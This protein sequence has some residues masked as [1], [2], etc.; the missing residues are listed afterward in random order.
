MLYFS[1]VEMP[2]GPRVVALFALPTAL[3]FIVTILWLKNKKKGPAK[4]RAENGEGSVSKL[5]AEEADRDDKTESDA[6]GVATKP[7]RLE[8]EG[9]ERNISRGDESVGA[10]TEETEAESKE[11]EEMEAELNRAD[12]PGKDSGVDI[13]TSSSLER[14]DSSV[15][16]ETT[17]EGSVDSSTLLAFTE[18]RSN[19]GTPPLNGN[20]KTRGTRNTEKDV[21]EIEF[22]Q[23]LCG[24]LIGRKGKN[25]RVISES[26]GAKIR[27]IPQSPG[28]VATHRIISITGTPRQI[29]AALEAIHEKFPCVPLTRL[30]LPKTPNGNT[31][32]AVAHATPQLVHAVLPALETFSVI[33]TSVLDAGHFFVQIHTDDF[34]QGQLQ[35]L[36]QNMLQYYSQG[37]SSYIPPLPQPIAVGCYCAAPAYTYDGWYRAQVIQPTG[38]Q[39]EVQILY[40]DYGGFARVSASTLRQLR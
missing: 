21:W 13:K 19:G 27:L 12:S 35:E 36:H 16:E 39:D 11:N 15:A 2:L 1:K 17:S 7:D 18:A 4:S 34:V 32:I 37:N 6:A 38:N 22:P 20:G 30:N 3:A 25:V 29:E 5:T 10:N 33:V 26:S 28:E 23:I 9:K 24:R 8:T 14:N 40:M 31:Q